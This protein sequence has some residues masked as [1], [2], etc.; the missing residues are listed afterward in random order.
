NINRTRKTSNCA[1][2]NKK[3]KIA[4]IVGIV[5]PRTVSV[6]FATPISI[7][8]IIA[9]CMSAGLVKI[10]VG[11]P[12]HIVCKHVMANQ[13]IKMTMINSNIF[14]LSL[15]AGK[16]DGRMIR[17]TVSDSSDTKGNPSNPARLRR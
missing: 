9:E 12:K 5:S 2:H 14:I 4:D 8:E 15:A 7:L 17:N 1:T 10:V 11:K 16:R 6:G 3:E 13:M